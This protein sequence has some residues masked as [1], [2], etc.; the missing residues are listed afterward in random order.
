MVDLDS[1]LRGH[2][3]YTLSFGNIHMA[4]QS[5]GLVRWEIQW[6]KRGGARLTQSLKMAIKGATREKMKKPL[7]A[8]TGRR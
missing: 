8:I 7:A 6:R 1:P 4:G 5:F 2:A 3:P